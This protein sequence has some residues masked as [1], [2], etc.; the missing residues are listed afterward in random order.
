MIPAHQCP[1]FTHGP[2]ELQ[3]PPRDPTGHDCINIRFLTHGSLYAWEFERDG[4]IPRVRVEGCLA[5]QDI[6][7]N[8]TAVP[9]GFG[10][11]WLP[12]DMVLADVAAGR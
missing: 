4:H 1:W 7:Q 8:H 9:D 11:A 5:F 10:L 2:R 3:R 12:E 6:R